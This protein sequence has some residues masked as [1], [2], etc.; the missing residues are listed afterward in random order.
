MLV[1]ESYFAKIIDFDRSFKLE[2]ESENNSAS[3]QK[4]LLEFNMNR[5]FVTIEEYGDIYLK[6][7]KLIKRQIFIFWV[8]NSCTC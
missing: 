3:F 4:H 5:Y 8:K 1:T 7:I 6:N 2:V